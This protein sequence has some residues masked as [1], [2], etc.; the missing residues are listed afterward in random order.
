MLQENFW[1]ENAGVSTTRFLVIDGRTGA[2]NRHALS[3]EAYT[4]QEFGDALRTAG[5]GDLE[6]SP[7]LTGETVSEDQDLPVVVARC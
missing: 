2:V 7:S 4:E 6:W 5:F 1:D 3:N